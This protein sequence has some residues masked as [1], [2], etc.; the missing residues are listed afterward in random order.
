VKSYVAF[1]TRAVKK[2]LR[3]AIS[4]FVAV[5][6]MA[7]IALSLWPKTYRSESTMV[8][9]RG[10]AL[11][12]GVNDTPFR[13][14]TDVVRRRESLLKIIRETELVSRFHAERSPLGR[15]K[16]WLM[17]AVG[18]GS[19]ARPEDIET[20][21]VFTLN[22]ALWTTVDDT[23][24]TI[25]VNWSSADSAAR[26]V[27]AAQKTVLQERHVAEIATIQEK[28]AI[29]DGHSVEVRKEIDQIADQLKGVRDDT[30]AEI[31][32]ATKAASTAGTATSAPPSRRTVVASAPAAPAAPAVSEEELARQKDALDEQKKELELKT[33]MLEDLKAQRRQSLA[34]AQAQMAELLTKYTPAH[35]D[36]RRVERNI[37]LLSQPS[38]QVATL[39][40]E[41]KAL[42]EKIKQ[43]G[44]PASK[45]EARPTRTAVGGPG[46]GPASKPAS[47]ALP[48]DILKLLESERDSSTPNPVTAQLNG[49][50]SKY[51]ALRE[52]IRQARVDLD[53]AQAAFAHRY[54]IVTPAEPPLKPEK[55]KPLQ[56]IGIGILAAFVIALAWPLVAELRTGVIVERWQVYQLGLPLLSEMRLPPG[57]GGD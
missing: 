12:A 36:V 14:A 9:N 53:T 40:Q 28:M 42:N 49:A 31:G 4:T 23:S 37:E 30:I 11:D 24:M 51:A 55:P 25:G 44:R 26:I 54:K 50:V 57:H 15:A 16:T 45:P 21:L 52:S 29:L 22:A 20:A 34:T 13:G 5:L 10:G 18:L 2:R 1:A 48:A 38:P 35:P 7:V 47:D 3:G 27:T 17:N 41:I 32:K 33:R 56:V 43:A 8:F 6:V 39:E 46:P 19:Q